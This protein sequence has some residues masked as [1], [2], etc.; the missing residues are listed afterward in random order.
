MTIQTLTLLRVLL[1]DPNEPIYGLELSRR[2]GLKT[3]TIYPALARLEQVGWVESTWEVADP[4]LVGRPRRRL[5][6]LTAEGAR[7]AR[8][9]LSAHISKLSQVRTRSHGGRRLRER[10]A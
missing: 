8:E 5:Y 3:G 6:L 10:T 1:D 4:A 7:N 2:A 9:A